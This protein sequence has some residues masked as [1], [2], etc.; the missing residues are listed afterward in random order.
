MIPGYLHRQI[1]QSTPNIKCLTIKLFRMLNLSL[2]RE[3]ISIFSAFAKFKFEKFILK[4]YRLSEHPKYCQS[5]ILAIIIKIPKI[6]KK[7]F[8]DKCPPLESYP[9]K[10]P[11]PGQKLGC[12]SPSKFL[13]QIPEGARGMAMDETDTC[14]GA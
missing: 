2:I 8:V 13:V 4:T 3:I 1:F 14:I 7:S 5:P 10:S 11:P 9:N 12:K 6:G